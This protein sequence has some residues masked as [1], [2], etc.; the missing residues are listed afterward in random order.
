M[1]TLNFSY[2]IYLIIILIVLLGT[3]LLSNKKNLNKNIQNLAIWGLI[4]FALL[5]TYYLWN[6]LKFSMEKERY[7]YVI[8]ND[9]SILIN[10]SYDGH[11]YLPLSINNKEIIFLVDTGATKSLL[12]KRDYK[13]LKKNEINFTAEKIIETANGKIIALETT[14]DKVKLFNNIIGDVTFLVVRDDFEGPNIS[15]LG[16]DLLD[17]KFNYQ[18]TNN[19]L[20]LQIIGS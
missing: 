15:L 9:N 2:L 6:E 5:V 3:F 11:F 1:E 17:N 19:Y 7:N 18:I 10:K 12:S 14:F 13:L 8:E 20:K 4:F 16:L